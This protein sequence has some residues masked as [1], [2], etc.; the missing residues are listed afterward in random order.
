LTQNS[1]FSWSGTVFCSNI[2]YGQQGEFSISVSLTCDEF[3]HWY[4]TVGAR[5]ILSYI[6]D[7]PE[8]C[9]TGGYSYSR[10]YFLWEGQVDI[11]V[12]EFGM[13]Q[14]TVAVDLEIDSA[15]PAADCCYACTIT[16]QFN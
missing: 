3:D 1:K 10:C 6:P 9:T 5:S 8:D 16:F 2:P 4:M 11:T 12:D 13:I 7:L 15:W 14:G